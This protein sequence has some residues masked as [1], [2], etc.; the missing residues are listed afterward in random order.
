MRTSVALNLLDLTDAVRGRQSQSP[1]ARG[2]V[3]FEK[4]LRRK[5]ANFMKLYIVIRYK[6]IS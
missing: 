1:A 6:E 3:A 2:K 4:E 5:L